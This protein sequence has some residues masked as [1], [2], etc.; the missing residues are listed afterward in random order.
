MID[1]STFSRATVEDIARLRRRIEASGVPA[2]I[3]DRNLVVGTWN[4]RAFGDIHESFEENPD[5][6]KRNLRGLALIAEVVRRFDILAVQELGR[7]TRALRL[8][9]REFLGPSWDVLLSDVTAGDEGNTER[10]AY[11]F[12]RR[13]VSPSG[14]AGEIVLPPS[15]T[16]DPV[17]Q[18]DRTPY[19]AG[20][21]VADEVL[22]LLT[23]H[24]KYGDAAADRVPELQQ[25]AD[26]TADEILERSAAADSEERNLVV[27]GDFNIDERGDNDLFRAFVSRGLVVPEPLRD[28]RTT[29][30]SDAKHYDQIAWFMGVTDLAF[31]GRAG[32]V[33]FVGA[34]FQE[35]TNLS[36]SFRVSDHLPLWAEF[37]IDR[38]E[39]VYAETL[40][41]D[42]AMPDPLSTVPD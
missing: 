24:I 20:F 19:L 29:F 27:L 10:M 32:T 23:A 33:D 3:A 16:G 2:K 36:M 35:L 17:D 12:D 9:L 40:G 18:F 38:S 34:V 30:G 22:T 21:R 1:R 7:S 28:L 41:V 25:M 14:L 31:T 39:E 5:S 4:I 26:F 8:L 15:P 6:P 13:R 11:V 37:K 42:P